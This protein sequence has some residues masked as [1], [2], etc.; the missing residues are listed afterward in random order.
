MTAERPREGVILVCV[1]VCLS[2]STAMVFAATRQSLEARR[3]GRIERQLRQTE[4]LLQAGI[5]R[6]AAEL[7]KDIDY[8]GETWEPRAALPE[9]ESVVVEIR[10]SKAAEVVANGELADDAA[11]VRSFEIIAR[12]ARIGSPV[13]R[14]QRSFRLPHSLNLLPLSSNPT[15][16]SVPE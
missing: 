8:A 10:V 7:S 3:Q 1:L 16:S 14:T 6:V 5:G 15:A 13:L 12:L 2:V 9:Y 11:P 4:W